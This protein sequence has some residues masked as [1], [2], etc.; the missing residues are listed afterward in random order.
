[1]VAA[2]KGFFDH[3]VENK[4]RLT[5]VDVIVVN[6][7]NDEVILLIEIEESEMSP[8]KLLGDVFAT[9]MCNRFAVKIENENRNFEVS[10]RTRLII[11]GFVS[12]RNSMQN[13]ISNIIMPRLKRF[14][15]P[16]DAIQVDKI[17]IVIGKDI[18]ETLEKL[19]NEMKNLFTMG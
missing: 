12:N 10:P 17:K 18:S 7:D 16:D 19:K 1:M 3:K 6:N 4:N 15:L 14:N 11:A 9:V 13:K 5:D 2:I 8:K